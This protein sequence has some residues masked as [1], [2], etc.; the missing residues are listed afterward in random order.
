MIIRITRRFFLLS[1]LVLVTSAAIAQKR[2]TILHTNDVHSRIE[3]ISEQSVDT[4][5]AGKG[6]LIRV[7]GFAEELRKEIPDLL[8]FDN[9]DFCQGTPYY[10]L[11]RG[12]VEIQLMNAAG[13]S[14]ATIGN[15][16]FDFGMENLARLI[17]L[18]EFP[19]VSANYE[20][21]GSLLEGLVKPY[22]ILKRNGL[23]IGVFGLGTK[24]K[25]MVQDA[26][27]EGVTYLDP[28][29]VANETAALL[30]EKGCDLVICLSHLGYKPM[31]NETVCD[32]DLIRQTRNI[33]L[34]LG[35]HSHTLFKEVEIHKNID[36]EPVYLNQAGKSGVNV[37][38]LDLVFD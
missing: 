17:R 28:Y 27:C 6:G 15:H 2:L 30:K 12:E 11:F 5:L 22:V 13:Y 23:T 20:V 31:P 37:G 25:G 14:A 33:D 21:T 35:G 36:G 32:L 24:L 26:N 34:V 8:L 1:L 9:G 19:F 4:L 7:A 29:P 38:R 16:E 10:N 3:A 18:A